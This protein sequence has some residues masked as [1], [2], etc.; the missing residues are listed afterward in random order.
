MLN[1]NAERRTF[2]HAAFPL[3]RRLCLKE[4]T[5]LAGAAFDPADLFAAEK[6]G[7]RFR[8]LFR[9]DGHHADAHVEDLIHF[10][11]IHLSIFLQHLEDRGNP[12]AAGCDY[13]I[14]FSGQ[15]AGKIIDQSSACNV[16]Q[17]FQNTGRNPGQERLIVPVHSE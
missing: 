8:I 5:R 17:S 9:D 13:R 3:A 4:Q 16:G 6:G 15:D 14:A 7:G 12:P 1:P 11:R 2:V 10:S